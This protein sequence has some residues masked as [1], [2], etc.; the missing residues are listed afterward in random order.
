M[1]SC[2]TRFLMSVS[3]VIRGIS[4]N[5]IRKHQSV[6][7]FPFSKA[8]LKC[9]TLCPFHVRSTFRLLFL[10][11]SSISFSFSFAPSHFSTFNFVKSQP[12]KIGVRFEVC[13]FEH[14]R[15]V[16]LLIK[17]S[18]RFAFRSENCSVI[19]RDSGGRPTNEFN[20]TKNRFY[21]KRDEENSQ[22]FTFVFLCVEKKRTKSVFRTQRTRTGFSVHFLCFDQREKY[23]QWQRW[24]IS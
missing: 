13:H 20:E 4:E 8:L 10:S 1:I 18:V 17:P 2:S 23:R 16:C 12:K 14:L 9:V 7:W 19:R 24:W 5:G 11:L 22:L 21:F 15:F 6:A 3:S